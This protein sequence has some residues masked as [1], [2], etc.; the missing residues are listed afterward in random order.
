M[1]M[2]RVVQGFRDKYGDVQSCTKLYKVVQ[3]CKGFTELFRV[4]QSGTEL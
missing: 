4:V 1:E 2:Y 3:N